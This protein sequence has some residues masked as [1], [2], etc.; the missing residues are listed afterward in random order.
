MIV[1]M[2]CAHQK[3]YI[4]KV[5]ITTLLACISCMALG[6]TVTTS[7]TTEEKKDKFTCHH[8]ELTQDE[9]K[10]ILRE[11]VKIET[12]SLSLEADSVV[13]DTESRVL[14]AYNPKNF[15]FS[16]GTAVISETPH[17]I[18]RYRLKDKTIY[19]D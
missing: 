12:E 2:R 16:G 13:F 9:K 3:L 19:I 11:D 18:I 4:M 10:V 17:N 15:T 7:P 6:Q 1:E 14:L 8:L 5:I